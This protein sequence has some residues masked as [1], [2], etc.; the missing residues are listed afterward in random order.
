MCSPI[1]MISLDGGPARVVSLSVDW[2][3]GIDV[4]AGPLCGGG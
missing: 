3:S 1:D 2:V 4:D